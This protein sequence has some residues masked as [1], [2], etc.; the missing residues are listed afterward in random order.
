[1]QKP[2]LKQAI[3]KELEEYIEPIARNCIE[4]VKSSLQ[5][6]GYEVSSKVPQVEV[7]FVPNTILLDVKT[8]L[9]IT[10]ETTQAYES[11]KIDLDSNLYKMI[12]VASSI[13]N[14]E[15]RYGDSETM[16]YMFYYPSLKVEKKKQSDGTTIYILTNRNSG[17]K[18]QFAS[19]SVV[20]PAGLIGQ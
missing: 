2:F 11:I 4:S 18:F 3:E 7:S 16:N 5:N 9:R 12:M 6:K 17:E 15:A 10:K 19:K 20:L 13:S 14:W 8:D 1:M